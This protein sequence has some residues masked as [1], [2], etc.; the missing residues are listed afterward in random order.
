[1]IKA[2]SSGLAALTAQL[3]ATQQR[4]SHCSRCHV[5]Q[6][7]AAAR[8]IG[9]Q[10]RLHGSGGWPGGGRGGGWGWGKE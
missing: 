5:P 7:I 1:M 6:R 10:R 9:Q 4:P 2:G 8:S 3:L